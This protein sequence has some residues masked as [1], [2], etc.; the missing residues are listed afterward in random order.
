MRDNR[1]FERFKVHFPMKLKDS[2]ENFGD[3]FYL[4]DASASGV[5]F[6]S[7]ERMYL[8]DHINLEV[9]MPED[10]QS[11]TLRGEV[12]W[13]KN[14]DYNVWDVGCK[15]HEVDLVHLSNLYQYA[16]SV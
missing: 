15:F 14:K 13:V 1:I 10:K 8:Y 2:L 3:N 12:V 16:E 4:Q 7:K 11:V 5:R 6:S 9:E